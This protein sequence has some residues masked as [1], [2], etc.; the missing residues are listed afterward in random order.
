MDKVKVP[1]KSN[2]QLVSWLK[3]NGKFEC[4]NKLSKMLSKKFTRYRRYEFVSDVTKELH[5]VATAKAIGVS[6][7]C[8]YGWLRRDKITLRGANKFI[9][10]FPMYFSM[11]DF[12][13]FFSDEDYESLPG[14][15]V[16]TSDL[17]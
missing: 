2:K 11:K 14:R 13:D 5:A 12:V 8:M 15:V 1:R 17:V 9:K 4:H 16:D 6:N 10:A 3:D 7:E